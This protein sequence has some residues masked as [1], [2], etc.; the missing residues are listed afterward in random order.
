VRAVLAC[1]S[2]PIA[3]IA[4]GFLIA[5]KCLL[6]QFWGPDEAVL[7]FPYSGWLIF[8][9]SL[10]MLFI[11]HRL[12]SRVWGGNPGAKYSMQ[13]PVYCNRD[14]STVDAGTPANHDDSDD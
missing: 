13:L 5:G 7:F 4:D 1:S 10:I 9:V 11:L 6:I 12:I 14:L 2:V 3:I 8:A